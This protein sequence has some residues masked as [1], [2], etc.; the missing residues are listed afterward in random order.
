MNW[1][2]SVKAIWRRAESVEQKEWGRRRNVPNVARISSV[3]NMQ[4]QD[5]RDVNLTE[6]RCRAGIFM[7]GE[8]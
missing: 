3:E 4:C 5:I 6:V 8:Q 2:S 1:L 7:G